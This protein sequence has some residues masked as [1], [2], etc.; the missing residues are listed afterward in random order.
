MSPGD[1]EQTGLCML[2]TGQEKQQGSAANRN[3]G[4][5]FVFGAITFNAKVIA[6]G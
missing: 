3:L 6:T 2:P 1:P 4:C 5:I